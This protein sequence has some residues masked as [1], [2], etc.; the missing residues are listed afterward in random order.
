[1][2]WLDAGSTRTGTWAFAVLASIANTISAT[3]RI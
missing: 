1:M 2:F 3:A